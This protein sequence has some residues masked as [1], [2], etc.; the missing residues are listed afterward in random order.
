M[1]D[2]ATVPTLPSRVPVDLSLPVIDNRGV[3]PVLEGEFLIAFLTSKQFRA[4]QDF[5]RGFRGS[6]VDVDRVLW[7]S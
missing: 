3:R 2:R 7:G 1:A 4:V 6:L 5:N